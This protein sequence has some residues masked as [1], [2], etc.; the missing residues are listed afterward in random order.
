MNEPI[1]PCCETQP[2]TCQCQAPT[3]RQP[4]LPTSTDDGVCCGPPAGPA[5]SPYDK[6]GYALWPFVQG[7]KETAVGP[8][9]RV[10]THLERSDTLGSF[11]V[12]LG[13][14]RNNYKI[15]PG[16]YCI[17]DPDAKAPVVVTANYKLTF[18]ILRKSMAGLDAWL[19]VVDTRGINVWCAAGKGTFSTQEVVQR[20]QQ[21]DLQRVVQ[22]NRLILPQLAATGVS[23]QQ[24]KKKCGFE[25]IWGPIRAFDIKAFLD[26]GFVA[27]S[28]MR[29]VTFGL[30][31]RLVLIPVELSNIPKYVLWILLG[32][33][34][35]S[36]IGSDIF[37]FEAAWNR[38]F[39]LLAAL[40]SGIL[41]G[42]VVVPALLPWIPGV[43][44]AVKGVLAGLVGWAFVTV[45][46]WG[47]ATYIESMALLLCTAA[48][49]SF[50]AMNFTGSTPFTS[51]SGVEKEMRKAI[52]L[53]ALAALAA[54]V[55]WVGAAFAG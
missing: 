50:M 34:L 31:E 41:A 22:H 48:L 33:F 38:G 29:Q 43:A 37:S 26:A 35:L 10:K 54:L 16:L 13:I 17:G 21:I 5:S 49:S 24:V 8:V 39:M 30:Q 47:Q 36:G 11:K 28:R 20:V 2:S 45:F 23:A 19:V 32:L 9:P 42:A 15:A 52:P 18:D 25:V 40:V 53:Q 27:S 12:R 1:V 6:P 3:E 7:F 46:Y 44:F 4:V 55:T 14:N 51:P